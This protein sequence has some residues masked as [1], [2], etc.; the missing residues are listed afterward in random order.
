LVIEGAGPMKDLLVSCLVPAFGAGLVVAS[1][2]G[3]TPASGFQRRAGQ[4][5]LARQANGFT[6]R[7]N[8][9]VDISVSANRHYRLTLFA[10]CLDV[11]FAHRVALRGRGGSSWICEGGD[12]EILVN[13]PTGPQRCLVSDI[14][15]LTPEE[16]SARNRRRR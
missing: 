10:P 1:V 8:R 15:R 3:E 14:R 12:A 6:S 11:D 16:V 9:A 2:A 5:F 7:D 4:C 13:G